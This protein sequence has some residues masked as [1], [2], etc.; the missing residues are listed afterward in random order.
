MFGDERVQ[1]KRFFY[2]NLKY[3]Q[4]RT[5]GRAAFNLARRININNYDAI[6][7]IVLV[8]KT[9]PSTIEVTQRRL[10]LREGGGGLARD[11]GK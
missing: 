11:R 1:C 10:R 7:K 4:I 3:R 6:Y 8:L 5:S 9:A 2:V